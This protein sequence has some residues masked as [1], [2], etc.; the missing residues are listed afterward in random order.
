MY[1]LGLLGMLAA[2]QRYLILRVVQLKDCTLI[3]MTGAEEFGK[4]AKVQNMNV[5]SFR[6]ELQKMKKRRFQGT[7][8]D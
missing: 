1:F 8:V 5:K 7:S 4:V 3:V 2:I 6:K